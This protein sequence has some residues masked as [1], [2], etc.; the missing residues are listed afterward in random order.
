MCKGKSVAWWEEDLGKLTEARERPAMDRLS[1][2]FRD[3]ELLYAARSI[4]GRP[5][6]EVRISDYSTGTVF[7][8]ETASGNDYLLVVMGRSSVFVYSYIR[9]AGR[10][11]GRLFV[12]SG[13]VR[14]CRPVIFNRGNT[15]R[16]MKLELLLQHGETFGSLRSRWEEFRA[17]V[18]AA[19]KMVS[20]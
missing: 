6:I 18:S 4:P 15:S 3:G 12:E 13:I 19:Q 16:V 14:V 8:I 5:L 9:S 17:K 20:A 10:P 11:G 1:E 2:I 7:R